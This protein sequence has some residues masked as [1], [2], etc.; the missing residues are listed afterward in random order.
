MVLADKTLFIAGPPDLMDEEET[1]NKLKAGDKSVQKTLAKQD[2][3]LTGKQGGILMAVSV[4]DG[5]KLA[6][7]RLTSL[8]VW[9]GMAVAGGKLYLTTIDGRVVCLKGE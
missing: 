5:K 2:A 3:A 1:F 8:P 4:A 6:E 9:D 7:L